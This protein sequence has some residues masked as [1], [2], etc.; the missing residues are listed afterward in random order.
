MCTIND[1]LGQT[2]SPAIAITILTWKLFCEI[3]KSGDGR[4]NG[5][6]I[7]VK[8]VITTG[9]DCGSVGQQNRSCQPAHTTDNEYLFCFA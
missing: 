4:T 7:R 6:T 9:R 3:L 5:Q 2:H 8:M 1:P